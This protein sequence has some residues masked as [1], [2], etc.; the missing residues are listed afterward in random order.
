[1]V[2]EVGFSAC[3]HARVHACEQILSSDTPEC[4]DIFQ[5]VYQQSNQRREVKASP[6]TFETQASS[7][8]SAT[9][10]KSPVFVLSQLASPTQQ[11]PVCTP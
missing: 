5:S 3:T 8:V 2:W 4:I 1:M 11:R 10:A 6:L 9:P 7:L